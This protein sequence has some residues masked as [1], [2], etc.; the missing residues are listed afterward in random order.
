MARNAEIVRVSPGPRLFAPQRVGEMLGTYAASGEI[1]IAT[2]PDFAVDLRECI[3]RADE[4]LIGIDCS[5]VTFVDSAG[6]HA[7]V[8]ATAYAALRG[9]SL[10]I[11]NPPPSVARLIRLCDVGGELRVEPSP[12]GAAPLVLR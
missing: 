11:R 4:V 5:G 2:A 6:Y 10:E 9:R 1:D 8:D 12:E 3:E 7:L